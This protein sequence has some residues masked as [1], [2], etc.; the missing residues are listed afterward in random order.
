MGRVSYTN[1]HRA[2]AWDGSTDGVMSFEAEA[3]VVASEF[4][5]IGRPG[6]ASP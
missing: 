3:C 2:R 5:I 1:D 4:T 6:G